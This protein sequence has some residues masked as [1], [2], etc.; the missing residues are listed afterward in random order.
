MR[1]VFCLLTFFLL[2]SAGVPTKSREGGKNQTFLIR[3][4]GGEASMGVH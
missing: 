3:P 4:D 1:S 2:S